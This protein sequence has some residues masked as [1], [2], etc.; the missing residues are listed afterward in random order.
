M[1]VLVRTSDQNPTP[2]QPAMERSSVENVPHL[3]CAL[4]GTAFPLTSLPS[5]PFGTVWI[6][7][8]GKGFV[9]KTQTGKWTSVRW[10]AFLLEVS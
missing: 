9:D 2:R 7:P 8:T 6:G 10:Y 5:H 4:N 3:P 1:L